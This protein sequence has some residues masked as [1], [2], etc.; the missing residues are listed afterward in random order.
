MPRQQLQTLQVGHDMIAF[1]SLLSVVCNGC[2]GRGKTR[3][4]MRNSEPVRQRSQ[5]EE[6]WGILKTS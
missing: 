2:F 3:Q 6:L 4:T 5:L 1:G